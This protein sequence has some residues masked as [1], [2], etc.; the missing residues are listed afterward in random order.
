MESV[1]LLK[2]AYAGRAKNRGDRVEPFKLMIDA[3]CCLDRFYGGYF[4]G[5]LTIVYEKK[6][7]I[8]HV[9]V[10]ISFNLF[11]DWINGGQW[12][13]TNQF[14]RNFVTVVQNSSLDLVVCF[15]GALESDRLETEWKRKQE[16]TYKFIEEINRHVTLKKKPPP[17][18]VRHVCILSFLLVVYVLILHVHCRIWWVP[19]AYLRSTIRSTFRTMQLRTVIHFT[20]SLL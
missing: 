7:L 6:L 20:C 5:K 10:L 14:L 2:L 11:I 12:S 19:P 3:E 16:E 8:L 15:N 4:P 17:K 18:Y 1:D 13:K 9:N